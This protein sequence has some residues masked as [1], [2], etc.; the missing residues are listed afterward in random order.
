MSFRG[1]VAE[2]G[3][4][5]AADRRNPPPVMSAFGAAPALDSGLHSA[6]LHGPGMTLKGL[7]TWIQALHA[8]RQLDSHIHYEVYIKNK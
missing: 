6:A 7:L 4:Q 3:I 8:A 5:A 2:P 1:R